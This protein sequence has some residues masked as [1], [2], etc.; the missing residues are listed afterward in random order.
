ME[1]AFRFFGETDVA[2]TAKAQAW[3]EEIVAGIHRTLLAVA[4]AP[5]FV[6]ALYQGVLGD[7]SDGVY[8]GRAGRNSVTAIARPKPLGRWDLPDAVVRKK[9]LP[10]I[11]LTPPKSIAT[12]RRR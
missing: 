9:P 12:R 7:R 2:P 5:S 10:A 6:E 11:K 4:K 3:Q 1:E 8:P